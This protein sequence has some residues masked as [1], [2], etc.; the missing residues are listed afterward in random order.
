MESIFN[1]LLGRGELSP[2]ALADN[3][4]LWM[5][6]AESEANLH[7]SLVEGGSMMP[8]VWHSAKAEAI[9]DRIKKHRWWLDREEDETRSEEHT[10]ELPSLMRL[11]YAVFCLKTKNNIPH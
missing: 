5:E 3:H 6:F 10:S 9:R 2:D 8:M 7:A 1:T 4:R 11:S